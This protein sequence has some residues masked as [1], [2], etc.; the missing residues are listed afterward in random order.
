[1]PSMAELSEYASPSRWR[2]LFQLVNTFV[3][4]VALW[5]LMLASLDVSYWLTL[6]LSVPAA[7]LLVRL[8]IIQ[9]DCGH[10]SFFGSRAANDKIGAVLGVMTLVPYTY[11][12][13]TH[14]V[15]HATSG[16]L[17][18]R[19]FGDV[20]TKTVREYQAMSHRQR[21]AYRLFRNPL[22]LFGFGPIYQFVIKHRYPWDLPREWKREWASVHL[23]NLA[24]VGV[25]VVAHFSVGLPR[26]F[27]VYTPMMFLSGF[28][29][30]WLFYVQHQYEDTYWRQSDQWSFEEAAMAGSSYYDLPAVV[31]WFTG[32][33]GV[34][35]IH[36]FCSHIP[37]YHL[38]RCFREKPALQQ[39]T[40]LTFFASL[41]CAFYKLWD[42]E[43]GKLVG[44]RKIPAAS[45]VIREPRAA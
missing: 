29:G 40:R 44:Y 9:H 28:A 34:H 14:A 16:D 38:Q 21:L 30:V 22:L 20:P 7:G 10:G 5:L 33:I 25:L 45:P 26:F 23:T 27:M 13:K 32:N 19:G 6:L 2:A 15:H 1:M 41:K 42:E 36:H 31:H 4:Y 11:W 18:R 8:F 35:H 12:R 43:S 37:N 3:P 24:L 17:E 39:V